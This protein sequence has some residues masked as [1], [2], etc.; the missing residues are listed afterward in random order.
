MQNI[1]LLSGLGLAISGYV[2]GASI[3]SLS[4]YL[5]LV[6]LTMVGIGLLSLTV[7][8]PS[9]PGDA[10]VSVSDMRFGSAAGILCLLWTG[11]T[12]AWRVVGLQS[13]SSAATAASTVSPDSVEFASLMSSLFVQAQVVMVIWIAASI[14]LAIASI[15]FSLFIVRLTDGGDRIIAWP[16]FCLLSAVATV[17]LA[18]TLMGLAGGE[19]DFPFLAMAAFLKLATLPFIG[20]VAYSLLLSKLWHLARRT[21][22]S[23]IS[24]QTQDMA[25]DQDLVR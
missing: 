20:I 13:L 17:L 19:V 24:A 6:G 5:D 16:F 21:T 7:R 12:V 8:N 11:L 4:L 15:L 22:R 14:A 10:D 25:T 1:L 3:F 2:I 18:G 23:G 9:L